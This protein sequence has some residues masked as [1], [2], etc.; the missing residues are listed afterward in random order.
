MTYG[1][2]RDRGVLG[3]GFSVIGVITIV[4]LPHLS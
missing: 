2:S 3:A 4:S 1:N